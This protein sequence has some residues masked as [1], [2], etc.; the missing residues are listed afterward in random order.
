MPLK[1]GLLFRLQELLGLVQTVKPVFTEDL[2]EVL[3]A[4]TTYLVGEDGTPWSAA[5]LCPCGCREVIQL[6]L[7]KDDK[8]HWS[9]YLDRSGTITFHPSIW[10][11]K[12]CRSHFFIRDSVVI[13][14]KHRPR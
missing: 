8:P 9:A 3:D 4:R 13:W 6:S 12:G 10:R 2:P 5:L 14:A 7:I 11:T 1:K